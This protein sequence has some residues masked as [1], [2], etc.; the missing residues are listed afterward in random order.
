M[1]SANFDLFPS[2]ASSFSL[3]DIMQAKGQSIINIQKNQSA[4]GISEFP[5][6]WDK[7]YHMARDYSEGR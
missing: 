4:D 2:E 5:K 7:V 3:V 1:S 6:I